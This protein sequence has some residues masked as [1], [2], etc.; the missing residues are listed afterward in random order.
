MTPDQVQIGVDLG[1]TKTEIIAL[2]RTT[3]L[4]LFRKRVYKTRDL[5]RAN[6]SITFKCST[7]EPAVTVIG[8][9]VSPEASENVAA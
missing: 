7:T 5:V 2:N 4:E 6:I 1:G 8:G 9:G 3:G